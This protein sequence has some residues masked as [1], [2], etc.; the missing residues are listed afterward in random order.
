M[1]N[2]P[3][4]SDRLV[5]NKSCLARYDALG[6]A[7]AVKLCN[8]T[9]DFGYSNSGVFC[10]NLRRGRLFGLFQDGCRFSRFL[11]D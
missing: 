5:R 10:G 7:H 4:F 3:T 8:Q 6:D 2:Q 9:G 11:N 1:K